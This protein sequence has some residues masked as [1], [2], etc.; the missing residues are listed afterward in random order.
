MN[1]ICKLWQEEQQQQLAA[2]NKWRSSRRELF[3]HALCER[4]AAAEKA[5]GR[6]GVRVRGNW[7]RP[8]SVAESDDFA[9]CGACCVR[10]RAK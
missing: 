3:T 6:G 4:E 7:N 1:N 2:K 10:L 5:E 8:L 9:V